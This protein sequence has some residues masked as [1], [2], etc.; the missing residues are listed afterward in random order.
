MGVIT[1]RTADSPAIGSGFL[2]CGVY[3]IFMDCDDF[4]TQYFAETSNICNGHECSGDPNVFCYVCANYIGKKNTKKITDRLV[5]LYEKCFDMKVS[6]PFENWIPIVI[7]ICH[8][9]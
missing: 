2:A 5:I 8:V 9:L 6:L 4:S 1:P 7:C 3:F